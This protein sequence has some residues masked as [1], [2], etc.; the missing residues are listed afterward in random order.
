MDSLLGLSTSFSY[1][2]RQ[3]QIV[4]CVKRH[5]KMEILL[6]TPP[7]AIWSKYTQTMSSAALSLLAKHRND[8]E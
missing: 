8:Y 3:I 6:G 7:G 2:V 5:T 4:N 1:R